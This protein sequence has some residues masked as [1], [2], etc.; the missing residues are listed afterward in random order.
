MGK[1]NVN[2]K[3]QTAVWL[4]CMV[5]M[6]AGSHASTS[7]ELFSVDDQESH[8]GPDDDLTSKLLVDRTVY[9]AFGSLAFFCYCQWT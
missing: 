3:Q 1:L 9:G 6:F 2:G 4:L 5:A 7:V 8:K